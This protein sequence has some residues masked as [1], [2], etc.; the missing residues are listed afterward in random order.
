MDCPLCNKAMSPIEDEGVTYGWLCW[1]HGEFR[2][3]C[4]CGRIEGQPHDMFC[5]AEQ[6]DTKTGQSGSSE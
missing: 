1:D 3:L 6:N 2:C 5:K 4:S